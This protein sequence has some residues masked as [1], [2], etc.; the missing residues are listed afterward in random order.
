MRWLYGITDS[1]DMG[2]GGLWELVMDK[3][4]WHAAIHRVAKSW[5]WLSDWTELNWNELNE[6]NKKQYKQ[7]EKY[8]LFLDR[9]NQYCENHYTT[10]CNLQIQCDPYQI[11]NDIFHRTKYSTIHMESQKTL[12]AETILREKNGAGG[13][14]LPDFRLYYKVTVTKTVWYWHKNRDID[15]CNKT[16][17]P[18]ISPC[19]YRYLIFCKGITNIQWGKDSLFN[20]WL[21][22]NLTA[23]H[24]RMKLK[25]FL[26]PYKK[27]NSKWI[28]DLSVRA[29]TI[30]HF[31]EIRGEEL[32]WR[33]SRTGRTLSSP[34]IHQKNI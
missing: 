31:E 8:S 19:T 7:M 26:T 30:K 20:K 12:K 25:H 28:K 32:R 13:I 11:A 4:T 1:M 5:T 17:I 18:E 9:K 21:C 34:Q 6:K 15:Q 24:K 29:E 14:N 22:E 2:L 10:K 33:R 3:E 16:E 27:I 23:T